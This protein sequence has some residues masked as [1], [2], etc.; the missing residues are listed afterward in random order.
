MRAALPITT[1]AGLVVLAGCAAPLQENSGSSGSAPTF[2]QDA[3]SQGGMLSFRT[4]R[5]RAGEAVE[6][7][8]RPAGPLAGEA[9]LHLRARLRTPEHDT[10]N[11]R[12]G[13]QTLAVL[14][15]Q[16]DGTYRGSFSVP[17][18]VVYAAFAVE[19]EAATRTDTREGRFWELFVHDREGRPLFAT[20]EQRLNDHVGRDALAVLETARELVRH[21]PDRSQSWT[22]LHQA[23]DLVLS[24]NGIEER[25]AAHRERLHALDR[26][27]AE[28]PG[29]TADQ[30]GYLYRYGGLLGER[31]IAERWRRRLM[32]EHPGHVFAV[33]ERGMELSQKYRDDPAALLL[34]LEA[35][36]ETAVDRRAR[37]HVVLLAFPT[38]RE[39]GDARAL[40]HWADRE[41]ALQPVSSPAVANAL[42]GAPFT[43]E[44]G[45]RRLQEEIS[46]R[47]MASDERRPLGATRAEHR[48]SADQTA[49]VLRALLG[50]ALLAAGRTEEG[51][52][53]LEQSTARLWDP[54]WF[55]I[56]GE[57]HLA[58]GDRAGA[59]RAF[60]V[61]AADPSRPSETADSLRLAVDMAPAEWQE[62]VA[63]A[64]AEMLERTLSAARIEPVRPASGM[65]R[66]GS[67][68]RLETLLGDRASVV[69]FWSRYCPSSNRA[70]PQIAALA[71]ELAEKGV[72]LLAVTRDTPK[73]AEEYLQEGGWKIEVLYDTE[74]EIVRALNSWRTPQYFVLDGAGRL[75]FA[76]SSLNVLPR[77]T[78]AL[79]ESD[80]GK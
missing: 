77:Q 47:E 68:A 3:P 36:W 48:E 78:A 64:R 58:S 43:R 62:A 12:M 7:S 52:L 35:L 11:D 13:S 42:A 31:E 19:N 1:L 39:A 30:V 57:A 63:R 20:L 34:E 2:I 4:E 56:L 21:Y 28:D 44:E 45:I 24:N 53:A 59:I 33:Q 75:R 74:G 46:A 40:R 65:M 72:R 67:T 55:Q 71:N 26:A 73:E 27:L 79:L 23:E 70:M 15:R 51:V 69:V 9:R 54:R 8:Y 60:A 80:G 25:L 5:P 16:R 76:S 50:R 49:A 29:L 38:A 66:D 61:V 14:K 6:V 10:Y 22:L 41:I 32:E 18:E 17:D 37:E